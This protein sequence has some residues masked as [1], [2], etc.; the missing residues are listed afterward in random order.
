MVLQR[1]KIA[2]KLATVGFGHLMLHHS[3][4]LVD[5]L[6]A[7][8]ANTQPMQNAATTIIIIIMISGSPVACIAQSAPN[9]LYQT[10]WRVALN[11]I[12][13]SGQHSLELPRWLRSEKSKFRLSSPKSYQFGPDSSR[14]R[15]W[16]TFLGFQLPTGHTIC[17]LHYIHV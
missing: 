16:L 11:Y 9:L 2:S 4:F 10:G 1:T 13:T 14:P 6:Q 3:N 12:E 17:T 15:P 8:V 5:H 7:K